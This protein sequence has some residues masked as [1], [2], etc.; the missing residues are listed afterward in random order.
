VSS[1]LEAALWNAI[2]ETSDIP[3]P[4]REIY[5]GKLLVEPDPEIVAAHLRGEQVK[6]TPGLRKRLEAASKPGYRFGEW[7]SDFV[8]PVF[9]LV[10]E[11]EGVGSLQNPSRHQRTPGFKADIQKYRLWQRCLGYRVHR[12]S[13]DQLK[14]TTI[15]DCLDDIRALLQQ[16]GW[17]P[18]IRMT[19]DVM[20]INRILR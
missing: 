8:W 13:N 16:Q 6:W 3:R 1:E 12:V 7:H 2:M 18:D 15:D 11:V 14:R 17:C 10:V 5:P 9:K 4:V 19:D 20:E